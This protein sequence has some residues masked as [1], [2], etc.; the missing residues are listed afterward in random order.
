MEATAIRGMILTS[1]ERVSSNI[2]VSPADKLR[3]EQ[4]YETNLFLR[5]IAAQLAE[6]VSA[7]DFSDSVDWRKVAYDLAA[8]QSPSEQSQEQL[9]PLPEESNEPANEPT[10]ENPSDTK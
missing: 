6:L 2:S 5:E 1:S 9:E 10:S 3:A 7:Q 4:Q 8:R